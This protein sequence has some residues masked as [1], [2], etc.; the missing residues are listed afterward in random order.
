MGIKKNSV[1]IFQLLAALKVTG[2]YLFQLFRALTVMLTQITCIV[3]SELG[4]SFF[5]IAQSLLSKP[6][7]WER[8]RSLR[9]RA[10][11]SEQTDKSNFERSA[12]ER[13]KDKRVP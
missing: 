6:S 3:K 8:W 12:H 1:T 10:E 4:I 11:R 2:Q 9:Q 5:E 7:F 13:Y